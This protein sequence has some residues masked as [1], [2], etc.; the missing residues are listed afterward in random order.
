[1]LSSRE[2]LVLDPNVAEELVQAVKKRGIRSSVISFDNW[3]S[4][5]GDVGEKLCE[6][7]SEDGE[8]EEGEGE[9]VSIIVFLTPIDPRSSGVPF[10]STF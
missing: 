3:R 8:G 1:M 6:A 10:A 7:A 4:V 5:K 2:H 9:E